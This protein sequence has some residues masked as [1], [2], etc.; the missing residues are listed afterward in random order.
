MKV[1]FAIASMTLLFCWG[2]ASVFVVKSDPL[3]S[4]VFVIDRKSGDKKPLGKTPFEMRF[5]DLRQTVGDET[6]AGEYFTLSVEKQGYAPEQVLVPA[7]RFGTLVTTL[8]V[9]LKEGTGPKE[10]RV[11]KTLLNH[12]FLAQKFA[13]SG[14][15]ERA[16]I[17]LDKILTE[18]PDFP[19]A[20]SMRGTIYYLQ[21][22]YTESLKWYEEALKVDPQ[23]EDTV[24]MTAKVR[25]LQ[26]GGRLPA[27]E[28]GSARRTKP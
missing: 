16:Q 3:Q 21:K 23:M 15:Y 13:K 22:N 7:S 17:E 28:S 24:Q 5:S 1:R 20:L 4:D 27:N 8:D 2:C 14:Q 10:E 19:R 26:S 6:L 11:A 18:A 25:T 9:K 12:L